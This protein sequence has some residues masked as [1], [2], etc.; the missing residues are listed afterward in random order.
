MRAHQVQRLVDPA[1]VVVAMIVPPLHFE[2]L[3]KAVH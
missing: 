2:R 1:V 3:K